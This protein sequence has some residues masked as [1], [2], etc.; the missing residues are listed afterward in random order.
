MWHWVSKI[1]DWMGDHKLATGAIAATVGYVAVSKSASAAPLTTNPLPGSRSAQL[2][3]NG[4]I[5]SG[6]GK[7]VPPPQISNTSNTVLQVTTKDE[8]AAGALRAR[9]KADVD[10]QGNPLS[11]I[12]GYWPKDGLVKLLDPGPNGVMVFVEGPGILG[13]GGDVVQLRAW[14]YKGFLQPA[15]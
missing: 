7:V 12:V 15:N 10:Q 13:Q 11:D 3:P 9:A 4:G 14:A 5:Q 8:G 2:L 1:V 6:D